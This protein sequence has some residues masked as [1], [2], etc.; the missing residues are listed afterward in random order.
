MK[1]RHQLLLALAALAL[2]ANAL[3]EPLVD[4]EP[5]LP[6]AIFDIRYQ[7]SYNFVGA[8]I[9]GYNAPKCLLTE[10]AADALKAV[11]LEAQQQGLVLKIF[12][13]YRPQQAV[14]HF[15]RW[16]RD[17][18]DVKMKHMFYPD[19]DKADLFRK[20]YIA[21]QSGHSRGSTVDLT[22]VSL[23]PNFG[24]IG[25][26]DMGTDY[27]YFD[28]SSHTDSAAVS[29]E[30]RNNRQLLKDLMERHGF[31]NLPEEWWHYSLADE[32]YPDTYFDDPVE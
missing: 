1:P 8:P 12:D 11:Q 21:K 4:M 10:A 17:R 19:V 18:T 25:E 24:G 28:P 14:D 13:C 32:P 20:G 2:S 26:L 6:N 9:D 16:A 31:T 23:T 30:I 3:S 5:L 15:V 22:L 27:D 7:S 29:D